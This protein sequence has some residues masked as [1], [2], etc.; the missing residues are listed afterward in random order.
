MFPWQ[1]MFFH[2][3]NPFEVAQNH[4]YYFASHQWIYTVFV[5]SPSFFFFIFWSVYNYVIK[6]LVVI[7]MKNKKKKNKKKKQKKNNRLKRGAMFW[8]A[9]THYYDFNVYIV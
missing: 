6:L 5:I 7:P 1:K 4:K 2:H 9:P 3:T 8:K